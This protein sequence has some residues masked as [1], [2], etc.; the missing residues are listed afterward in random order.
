MSDQMS[1]QQNQQNKKQQNQQNQQNKQQQNQKGQK[2]QNSN[3]VDE[4]QQRSNVVAALN[5][6]GIN[7]YGGRYERTHTIEEARAAFLEFEKSYVPPE[8]NAAQ[9]SSE[10]PSADGSSDSTESKDTDH[11]AVLE[12]IKIAGRIMGKRGKGKVAFGDIKDLSGSMQFYCKRDDFGTEKYYPLKKCLYVGDLLGIGGQIFR[13]QAGEVTIRILSFEFLGK[14]LRP[15][16]EKYHGLKDVEARYRHRSVDLIMNDEARDTFLKRFKMMSHIRH[17]FEDK[18]FFEVEGP[19]LH[20]IAGGAAATPFTTHHNALGMDLYLRIAL[21]LHLKRLIVGGFEKVFEIGRVFRNEGVSVRHNP[22][23]TMLEAYWAYA[24]YEDMMDLTEE[25]ISGLALKLTGSH[26]ITWEGKEFDLTAPWQRRTFD[27]LLQEHGKISL[28]DCSTLEETKAIAKANHI[29]FKPGIS[30]G[31]LLD[32]LFGHF[33]DAHL[34]GPIFVKD[35]PVA[36]S[37]LA[38]H[39]PDTDLTY[40]FE[41]FIGGMEI[42]NAF[43]EL[44]DAEDQRRRFEKQAAEK[45]A[46]DDEACDVDEDYLFALEHGMPSCGGIGFGLDRLMMLLGGVPSIRDVILFPHMRAK[47]EDIEG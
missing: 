12:N 29:D 23:F 38:K 10:D 18:G 39:I 26:K 19:V 7:P 16:P 43:S 8:S 37:P 40:R 22:E 27:D 44:N 11:G 21:E 36:L 30:H 3:R 2:K 46:G 42:C 24:D 17:F 14:A 15:L 4:K 35:Y 41:A 28:A 6:R 47:H 32:K 33:V 13:T 5:E 25:L 20:P 9:T 1:D 45:A 31:K 34:Q